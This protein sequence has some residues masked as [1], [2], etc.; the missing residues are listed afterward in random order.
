MFDSQVIFKDELDLLDAQEL[1]IVATNKAMAKTDNTEGLI[2]AFNKQF[3]VGEILLRNGYLQNNGK[4]K[5]PL[6]TSGSFAGSI[7]DGR[8]HTL[9]ESDNL[10]SNGGGAH[11]SFG[12]YTTLE[13][14][15]NKSSALKMAGSIVM[16]G[17][18]TWNQVKQKEYMETTSPTVEE[19]FGDIIKSRMPIFPDTKEGRNLATNEN[20]LAL[21]S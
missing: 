9:S 17:N 6:S 20:L 19:M 5:S 13:H 16:V 21:I 15:S 10:F 12:I 1:T 8:F 11:D 4:W 14:G 7:K 2:G 18:K 3:P